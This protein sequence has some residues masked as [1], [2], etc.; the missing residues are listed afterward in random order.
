M[1]SSISEIIRKIAIN[2]TNEGEVVKKFKAKPKE[3]PPRRNPSIQ[4]DS[5]RLDYM[6]NYMTVYREDGKDYQKKP[7]KIKELRKI[8]RQRLKKKKLLTGNVGV[9]F[10][11]PLYEFQI[12]EPIYL[13]SN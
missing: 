1:C 9:G 8:Q 10:N 3:K 6:K 11:T 2:L 5:N 4:N 13:K 7:E 12:I